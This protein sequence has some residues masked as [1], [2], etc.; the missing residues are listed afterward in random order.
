MLFR[1]ISKQKLN[2]LAIPLPP[3]ELQ[4][5]IEPFIEQSDKSKFELKQAIEDIN[6][7]MRVF[8]AQNTDKED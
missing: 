2:N 6:N 8:M 7:L 5:E 1:S 4:M 3:V